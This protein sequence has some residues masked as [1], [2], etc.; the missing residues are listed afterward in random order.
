M[1]SCTTI[2]PLITAYV[3]GALAD[4]NR[5]LVEGHL[6]LCPPCFARVTA[7]RAVARLCRERRPDL[8]ARAP[9]ALAARCA[10]AGHPAVR[11]VP[12]TTATWARRTALLAAAAAVIIAV[13]WIASASSTQVIASELALD[14]VKCRL[15]NLVLGTQ[16]TRAQAQTSMRSRFGWD[17]QLPE[18]LESEGLALVGARPCLYQHGTIAHLMYRHNGAL[19][20]VFMLPGMTRPTDAVRAL[21]H[22]A[23]IWSSGGRTFVVV[24][25]AG[26]TDVQRVATAVRT[27][28]R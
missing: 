27:A 3:D 15:M 8:Q 26:R 24:E 9:A 16:Q 28:L 4:A 22:E 12:R 23:V 6:R 20:S 14:H 1:S 19:A 18:R 13:G 17:V 5:D 21:G 7:E 10:R 11:R 25:K 2:D